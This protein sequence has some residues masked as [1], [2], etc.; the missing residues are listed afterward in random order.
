MWRAGV[1]TGDQLESFCLHPVTHVVRK[2]TLGHMLTRAR[3]W[4]GLKKN[5]LT[6][7][8]DALCVVYERN[9]GPKDNFKDFYLSCQYLR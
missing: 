9:K 1:V 2:V 4:I 7:L 6:R 5:K 8:A 3:F